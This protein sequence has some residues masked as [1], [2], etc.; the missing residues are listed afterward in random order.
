MFNPDWIVLVL[1]RQSSDLHN[2]MDMI[3]HDLKGIYLGEFHENSN[4]GTIQC[5]GP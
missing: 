1:I 2:P 5:P 4:L 3:R